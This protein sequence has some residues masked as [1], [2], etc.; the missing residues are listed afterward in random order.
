MD[1]ERLRIL[2]HIGDGV[3]G[4]AKQEA[5][6]EQHVGWGNAGPDG[7]EC[8]ANCAQHGKP[9]RSHLP[10]ESGSC[11]PGEDSPNRPSGHRKSIHGVVDPQRGL[12]LRVTGNEVSK[13][14]AVGEEK[15]GNG[16]AR[17]AICRGQSVDWGL[18][19]YNRTHA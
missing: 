17:A 18:H 7:G 12:D 4:T 2:A 11:Q 5:C 8:G 1:G 6:H 10:D 9:R 13:D 16:N 15:R 14:R 19:V 3:H